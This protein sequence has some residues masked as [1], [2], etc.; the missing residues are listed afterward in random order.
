MSSSG[1]KSD[2]G[3]YLC[4]PCSSSNAGAVTRSKFPR[5][6]IVA[7]TVNGSPTCAVF[8]L[9]SFERTKLPTAPPKSGGA[10]GGRDFT[11]SITGSLLI[12]TSCGV[13]GG[14]NGSREKI[15]MKG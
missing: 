13:L 6:V 5:P 11:S 14:N 2:D 7:V 1:L 8:G 12:F 10:P 9:A 15:S 4:H 3:G